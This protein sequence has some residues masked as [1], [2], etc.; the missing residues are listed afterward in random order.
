MAWAECVQEKPE[1][2]F[3]NKG[4]GWNHD[5]P[6]DKEEY[7]NCIVKEFMYG[8]HTRVVFVDE[9]KDGVCN[10]AIHFNKV[11][12]SEDGEPLFDIHLV[13][14]CDEAVERIKGWIQFKKNR[15]L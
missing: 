1:P 11:A 7:P 8:D 12:E 10:Y 6:P 4:Y 13:E 5:I 15:E 9:G 3:G 14:G 2:K